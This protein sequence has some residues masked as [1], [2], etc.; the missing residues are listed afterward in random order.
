M[1]LSREEDMLTPAGLTEI[2]KLSGLDQSEIGRRVGYDKSM[3]SKLE[4]GVRAMPTELQ[5]HILNQMLPVLKEIR[6]TA[7]KWIGL[8]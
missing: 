6:D 3:I 1:T 2:R 7:N 8:Q 4:R 5:V